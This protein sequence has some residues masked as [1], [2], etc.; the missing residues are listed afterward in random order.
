MRYAIDVVYLTATGG[1]VAVRQNLRPGGI[2]F[3]PG[4]AVDCLELPAGEATARAIAIG[5]TLVLDLSESG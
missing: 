1:V 2:S 5:D 4:T 3:G